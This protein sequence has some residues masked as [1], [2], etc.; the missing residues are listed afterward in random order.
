MLVST[1]VENRANNLRI[2]RK[3]AEHASPCSYSFAKAE[4][5]TSTQLPVQSSLLLKIQ[6]SCERIADHVHAVTE[7]RVRINH[8]IAYFR[9]GHKG[10]VWFNFCTSADVQEIPPESTRG[11][12]AHPRYKGSRIAASLASG[13]NSPSFGSAES[14]H[15]RAR[16][17]E[18]HVVT[19]TR[20]TEEKEAALAADMQRRLAE[21]NA[22]PCPLC[23]EKVGLETCS[24][25]T[26][27]RAMCNWMYRFERASKE[28]HRPYP[29]GKSILFPPAVHYKSLVLSL[30]YRMKLR[31]EDRVSLPQLRALLLSVGLEQASVNTIEVAIAEADAHLAG[32]INKR[33]FTRA[34]SAVWG[35]RSEPPPDVVAAS[36]DAILPRGA[37]PLEATG[38]AGPPLLPRIQ[39][40]LQAVMS[41][42]DYQRILP[43]AQAARENPNWTNRT[44]PCCTK[45]QHSLG[46]LANDSQ[47]S[48]WDDK[49]ETLFSRVSAVPPRPAP[50]P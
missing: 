35:K 22:P 4:L 6:A 23:E 1:N 49:L 50:P 37:H 44:V 9:V 10:I 13:I 42:K 17:A 32:F 26:V 18:P 14:S 12:H 45:C 20:S 41:R 27:M 16:S 31:E 11:L 2:T 28:L 48:Y 38:D 21:E 3:E 25:S 39:H 19:R 30:W 29:V 33:L 7:G 40:A 47:M 15:S 24:Y 46:L 8:L 43:P 34:V 5:R 36:Q